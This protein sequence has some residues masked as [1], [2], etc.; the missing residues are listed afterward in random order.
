MI[1][2]KMLKVVE[3][4]DAIA[5][6]GRYMGRK[7]KMVRLYGCNLRCKGCDSSFTW[8]GNYYRVD[9]NSIYEEVKDENLVV[10]TGGE[11]LMQ[12]WN[13]LRELLFMLGDKCVVETNGTVL[14][15]RC[16]WGVRFVVSPKKG[17][18]VDWS[19]W[20]DKKEVV[21][22]KFVIGEQKW[23]WSVKEVNEIIEKYKLPR[24]KVWL[25]P[26]GASANEVNKW[27]VKC[28]ES[29]IENGCNYS[30]RLHIRLFGNRR[31]V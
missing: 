15:L 27:A 7:C 20:T 22:Y 31:G 26:Y 13:G 19:F 2:G 14:P 18:D 1:V 6:E 24:E 12:Y 29:A 23:T 9:V 11:P 17:A 5:G 30:D 3:V 4:Y 25:M 8:D 10:I 16:K 28:W 21:D